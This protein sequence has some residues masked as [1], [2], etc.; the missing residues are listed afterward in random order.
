VCGAL[1]YRDHAERELRN[2]GHHI[3]RRTRPGK[4]GGT[5][6]AS[7][8]ERELQV[9]RLVVDRKTNSEI[10]AELF[11]ARRRSRRTC[12]TSSQDGRLVT[13]RPGSRAC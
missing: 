3:H 9:A 8:T 4:P 10:A 13:R 6:V 1:H 11:L 5:G 2:L 12:A 7:L